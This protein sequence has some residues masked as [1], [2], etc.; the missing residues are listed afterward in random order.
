MGN[1]MEV[2]KMGEHHDLGL[3]VAVPSNFCY[4]SV[5]YWEDE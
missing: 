4:T 3:K 2:A 1:K 5:S